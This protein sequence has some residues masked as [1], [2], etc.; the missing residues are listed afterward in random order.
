MK[1]SNDGWEFYTDPI[2]RRHWRWPAAAQTGAG[3]TTPDV[4]PRRKIGT[5][6]QQQQ[7]QAAPSP[8]P[9]K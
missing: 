3:M 5:L 9:T 8:L 1:A 4:G 2:G 6:R 7:A